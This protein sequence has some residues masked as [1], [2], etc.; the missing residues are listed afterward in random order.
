MSTVYFPLV[1]NRVP[2]CI[3]PDISYWHVEHLKKSLLYSALNS[4]TTS[5]T[6][7]LINNQVTFIMFFVNEFDAL[8]VFKCPMT[9]IK[10]LAWKLAVLEGFSI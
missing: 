10:H 5:L 4:L 9:A 3:L 7:H 6:Q 1:E 8:L 2:I